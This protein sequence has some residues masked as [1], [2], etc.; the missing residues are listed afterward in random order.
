MISH[1]YGLI[2]LEAVTSV[3]PY[4]KEEDGTWVKNDEL[5]KY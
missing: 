2:K 4:L 3:L 5:K 1:V